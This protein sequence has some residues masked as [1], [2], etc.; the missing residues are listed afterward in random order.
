MLM[1]FIGMFNCKGSLVWTERLCELIEAVGG[2]EGYWSFNIF[3][4]V[5]I[6]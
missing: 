3:I 6:V 1:I 2:F 4:Y 5:Y